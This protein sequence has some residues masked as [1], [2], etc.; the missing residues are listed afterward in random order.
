MKT[1]YALLWGLL[2]TSAIWAQCLEQL[3]SPAMTDWSAAQFYSDGQGWLIGG[4]GHLFQTFN[5][6][7]TWAQSDPRTTVNLR[8]LT[9]LG[10]T[11]GWLV[12]EGGIIRRTT[13]GGLSWQ[14]QFSPL[15]ADLNDI[16][17]IFSNLGLITGDCGT[18]LRTLNG[19]SSWSWVDAGTPNNLHTSLWI[20]AQTVIAVG[21]GGV[22]LR[23]G[24]SGQTWSTIGGTGSG[25]HFALEGQGAT[26]WVSGEGGTYYSD[27]AGLTWEW[28]DSRRFYTLDSDEAGTVVGAGANG[29]VAVSGDNGQT[30]QTLNLG[31]NTDWSEVILTGNQSG[32]L[33]GSDGN[34]AA[35][36]WINA[37]A[38]GPNQVCA[39]EP[40]QFIADIVTGAPGYSWTG[41]GGFAAA[42]QAVGFVPQ[43]SGWY[44]LNIE[45]AGCVAEDSIFLQVLPV[46]DVDLGGDVV[47]CE[48]E[49]AM[50]TGPDGDYN[51]SWSEGSSTPSL[52][53]MAGGA[54]GLTITTENGC[55]ASDLVAVEVQ[56]NGAF[57]IDTL[58]CSGEFLEVNG[59]F[60]DEFNPVGTEVLPGGAANGCD[61]LITVQI[62]YSITEP[63]TLDTTVCGTAFPFFYG[64]L[65]IDAPG[66]YF[67]QVLNTDG[68]TQMVFL[69][70]QELS[71]Y[72]VTVQGSFCQGGFYLWNGQ[73]LATAGIYTETFSASDGCDSTVTLN[74]T[75][76]S[77]SETMLD[78]A[79]CE[80]TTVEVGGMLFDEAGAYEVELTNAS[81]CDSIVYL[82][83][84]VLP[85]DILAESATICQGDIFL[86]EGMMLV[87]PGQYQVTLANSEGC[88]S[89]RQLELIVALNPELFIVDTLPDNGTG[90]GAAVLD[91]SQGAPPF[92]VS[93][94][95]GGAG[96]IQTSLTAGTYQ[97]TITDANDCSGTLTVTVPMTTGTTEAAPDRVEMWPNPAAQQLWV[98]LP[99]SWNEAEVE[100]LLYDLL[101]RLHQRWPGVATREA[102]ELSVPDGAYLLSVAY[103][104]RREVRKVIVAN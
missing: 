30:W 26:V 46:P 77:F 49:S 75:E 16:D 15:G 69:N 24:D 45:E 91:V 71:G 57:L 52:N 58:L 11:T 50:L 43:G 4:E 37:S 59:T 88:D 48:G 84:S 70:V 40:V 19:G 34:V 51:Y 61:S 67:I 90:N 96:L 102:L 42:G 63:I 36:R 9:F 44:V 68:C 104:D 97:V 87:D 32:Y 23:S 72:D 7:Q 20:N 10:Q 83:L 80:G 54:Y 79:V 99:D 100:L 17:F 38:S 41:P 76:L 101:G 6:G 64:G 92:E 74:L 28:Q 31:V 81:G 98:R 27:N 53:V 33:A 95:N 2:W 3:N 13:D 35:F 12:G 21:E 62:D 86:W 82:D 93:W 1:V 47:I 8:G 29:L 39:G 89:I 103:G 85:N 5:G 14:Q 22:V 94:S 65:E 25:D 78:L 55:I 60:Y 66:D 73:M 18:L 56:E